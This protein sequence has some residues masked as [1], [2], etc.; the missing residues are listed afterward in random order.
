M[1]FPITRGRR[2]R[3]SPSLRTL[4]RENSVAMTDLIAPLFVVPGKGVRKPI[5]SLEGHAHLST[6]TA[7][8]EAQELYELGV[9]SVLLF[10]LPE[11]KDEIGSS[12]WD[13]NGVVQQATRAIKRAL[14]DMVVMADVCFCEYTSHGHCGV[15]RGETVDNDATLENTAKQVISLA[16][17]GIDVVAPSG[18][19]DGVVGTIR[20]ALD[21]A[22]FSETA[23][24]A[25]SAKFASAFYGPFREAADST[26]AFG[27]R[28][29]YQMDPANV[30]EAIREVAMDVEEGADIVMVKPA[31]AYL[32]IIREVRDTF[33][34]PLACYN[35]SG[36]YAM[37][38]AASK[39]GLI[40][41]TAVM[42]EMLM[43]MKRAGAD[44]IISYFARDLARDLNRVPR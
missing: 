39:V 41:G 19:M 20:L 32:D 42:R 10:G 38:K 28:K 15:L 33:E 17:A 29:S 36:E 43:G 25:Y 6:D 2:L 5:S 9:R 8:Q 16:E 3:R 14:P 27:D 26:P 23:I 1:S 30:R 7:V 11:T 40:D 35:V 34:Q 18:M 21:E 22:G 13:E 37:V 24:M 44:L 4:V 31:L 12:S